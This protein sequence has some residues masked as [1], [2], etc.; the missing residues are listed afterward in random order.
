MEMC[1]AQ[2]LLY[3]QTFSHVKF[4]HKKVHSLIVCANVR[5]FTNINN[6]HYFIVFPSHKRAL[7]FNE[8]KMKMQLRPPPPADVRILVITDPISACNRPI[9]DAIVSVCYYVYA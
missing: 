1:K 4:K 5:R 6:F 7:I 9:T 2:V 3:F 8:M